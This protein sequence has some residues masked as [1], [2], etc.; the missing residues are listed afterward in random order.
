MEIPIGFPLHLSA[1]IVKVP[2]Q[3]NFIDV[4]TFLSFLQESQ[5]PKNDVC[6]IYDFLGEPEKFKGHIQHFVSLIL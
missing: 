2:D 1:L 4:Y 3:F 6:G 5:K